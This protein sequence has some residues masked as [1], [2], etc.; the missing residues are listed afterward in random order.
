M[1]ST[2]MVHNLL[3]NMPNLRS[4]ITSYGPRDRRAGGWLEVIWTNKRHVIRCHHSEDIGPRPHYRLEW[5]RCW[6]EAP[7]FEVYIW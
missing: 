4:R 7:E 3:K 5:E 2:L 1:D 6:Y